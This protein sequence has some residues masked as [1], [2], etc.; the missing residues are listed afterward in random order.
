MIDKIDLEYGQCECLHYKCYKRKFKL[1]DIVKSNI[2]NISVCNELFRIMFH[3]KLKGD[4]RYYRNEAK[5][6]VVSEI[7]GHFIPSI[8]LGYD[9]WNKYSV[10]Y[11][12]CDSPKT[13]ASIKLE[14]AID[15]LL[16]GSFDVNYSSRLKDFTIHTLIGLTEH[17]LKYK[18]YKKSH[19]VCEKSLKIL[20]KEGFFHDDKL[21]ELL[22]E[23][24][25][26][27]ILKH[28]TN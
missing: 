5:D 2:L 7:I 13:Y 12:V 9:H 11:I 27:N 10:S 1:Y 24:L 28:A 25:N 21:N 17:L 16:N 15:I 26:L 23:L 20:K 19:Q 3:Q 6:D 4:N 14:S 8:S 22:T 18:K